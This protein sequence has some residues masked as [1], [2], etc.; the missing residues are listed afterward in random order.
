MLHRRRQQCSFAGSVACI[1]VVVVVLYARGVENVVI[2]LCGL[3]TSLRVVL[4]VV[5]VAVSLL[6]RLA[7]L[8]FV[9]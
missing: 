1:A 8:Q 9:G 2:V 6:C 5:G 4:L 7:L 3:Q